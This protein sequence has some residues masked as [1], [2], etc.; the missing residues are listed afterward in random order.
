MEGGGICNIFSIYF[1]IRLLP[2]LCKMWI[3]KAV[4]GSS[5]RDA[6]KYLGEGVALHGTPGMLGGPYHEIILNYSHFRYFS[7]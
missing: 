7:R 4:V 1:V 2:L 5:R 3:N 6:P